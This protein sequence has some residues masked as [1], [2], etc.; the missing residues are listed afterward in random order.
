LKHNHGWGRL[1]EQCRDFR[2][3]TA[4]AGDVIILH[5]YML[6]APSQ[7]PSGRIRFMNNKVVS[8]KEPMRF[9]RSGGDYTPLEA[10]ILQ[11]LDVD[12]LD[13]EITGQRKRS[14]DFSRLVEEEV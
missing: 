8:L 1:I 2:E 3:M 9:Q 11:A 5:P 12:E 13:F 7:N 6:H 4:E 14:E 10:S